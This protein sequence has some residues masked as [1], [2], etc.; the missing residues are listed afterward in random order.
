M[1]E[2]STFTKYSSAHS[3]LN[4]CGHQ[5]MNLCHHFAACSRLAAEHLRIFMERAAS[6]YTAIINSNK[7]KTQLQNL[8][9]AMG[10]N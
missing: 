10:S 1:F 4:N 5:Q 6:L 8:S 7:L 2:P 3:Y 9:I